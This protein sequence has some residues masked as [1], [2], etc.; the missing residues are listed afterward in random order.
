[1][2]LS[3]IVA[4]W[5][6]IQNVA[7]NYGSSAPSSEVASKLSTLNAGYTWMGLNVACTATYILSMRKVI[8]RT[9]FTDWDS[10]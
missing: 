1:M 7:G 6:D 2:V 5:S 8:K 3:S 10:K 9:G 4:A